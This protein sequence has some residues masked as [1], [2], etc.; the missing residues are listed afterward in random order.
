MKHIFV[1][2]DGSAVSMG[3]LDFAIE[4]AKLHGAVLTVGFA[5][6]RASVATSAVSPYAYMDPT[7]LLQALEAEA[8]AVLGAAEARVKAAGVAVKRATIDGAPVAAILAYERQEK[9]DVIIMG[10]HGRRGLERLVIGST[11]EGVIRGSEVPVIV[12]PPLPTEVPQGPLGCLVVAVDGSPASDRGLEFA[13]EVASIERAKLALCS[14]AEEAHVEGRVGEVLAESAR[15]ISSSAAG[16][17]TELLHGD[18]A[19]GIVEAARTWSA[20]LI[21]MGTH[22]RAG[23][24]RFVLG[25]VAEGVLRLSLVPVCTVRHR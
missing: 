22:G 14:V 17:T 13:C 5:V 21:V 2:V 11:A 6:N 10:T 20:G 25:S 1:P 8:E 15:R 19:E 23:I 16:V 18:A 12:V 4:R 9:P 3:A 24:P 7:P